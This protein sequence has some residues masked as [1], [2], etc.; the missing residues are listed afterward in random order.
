MIAARLGLAVGVM[1]GVVASQVPEFAQQYRQRLGGAVDELKQVVAT[2]DA[3]SAGAGLTRETGISRLRESPDPF[4]QKRGAQMVDIA[5]RERRLEE[6]QA[7]L[8]QAGLLKSVM[9]VLGDVDPAVAGGAWEVFKPAVPVTWDGA[10]AALVGLVAG[11]GLFR[12]LALPFRRRMRP[13][14]AQRAT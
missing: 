11:T 1:A 13:G 9:V 14:L 7:A 4:V 10:I 8:A 5:I 2:F 6:Q 12:L 3:D